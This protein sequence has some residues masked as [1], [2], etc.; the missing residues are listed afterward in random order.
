MNT[1]EFAAARKERFTSAD[2]EMK[3]F[4]QAA[5][6]SGMNWDDVV[7]AAAVLWLEIFSAEAPQAFPDKVL[8][9]F[10]RDLRASLA[11]T[12][13]PT[14]PPSEV[15]VER[16]TLWIGTYTVNSATFHGNRAVGAREMKWV[17]MHDA[18][19]RDTHVA[20]DGQ[21]VSVNGTFDVGGFALHFPGEPVGPP[22]IWINCRCVVAGGRIKTMAANGQT[23]VAAAPKEF[24]HEEEGDGIH[25]PE[26]EVEKTEAEPEIE[27]EMETPFHGVL[28][29]E[30]VESG[31]GRMF[32]VG[33][34]STR[35][36]PIPLLYQDATAEGHDGAVVIGRIDE[37]WMQDGL[38]KYRGAFRRTELAEEVIE[39]IAGGFLRGVSVDIDNAE[40]AT[41][42]S[43]TPNG[44][45]PKLV[46]KKARTAAATVVAIPAFEEAFIALGPDFEEDLTDEQVAALAAC[47]CGDA[48]A[49]TFEFDGGVVDLSALT[50][51]ELDAYDEMTPEEQEAF[52][53][54]RGLLTTTEAL[55][56]AGTFAPGTKD[57]PGWVTNPKATS[58]IRRYWTHGKCAAKIKWG[59]PGDFNRCRAQLAKY[60]KNPEYLAGTCANMHKEALGIWPR[61]HRGRAGVEGVAFSR[62]VSL[63]AAA[64]PSKLPPGE[65]FENP[66]LTG[67]TPLTVTP[68]GRVFG[69]IATWGVCH[70]GLSG[71]CTTAPHSATEYAHFRTGVVDTTTGEAF[72]GQL[73]IGT[74]HAAMSAKA[75]AAVEHYDNTGTAVADVSVGEDAFGIWTAGVTRPSAT[76]QQIRDL[77]ASAISGDWRDVRG[78]GQLE[79]VAALAVNVPGFG[80]PRVAL[81]ASGGVQTALVAADIVVP[82]ALTASAVTTVEDMAGIARAAARE[83][84][85]EQAREKRLAAMAPAQEALKRRRVT[86]AIKK[87]GDR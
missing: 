61:S 41:E 84:L 23:V 22:E 30:G 36:L 66:N 44:R 50:P 73:T 39:G 58:R 54:E 7:E 12:A 87:I 75:R 65:W 19:V 29:P 62:S 47:G 42:G 67:P 14:N 52:V 80:V 8:E 56:A 78:N 71:V 21:T 26:D 2:A 15:Q 24:P 70:I 51:E 60:V 82:G 17:T 20:A 45:A 72:V 38:L 10:Q 4:V 25:M 81:A 76:E 40:L 28:A 79:L 5:L 32:A 6:S 46:F 53:A 85:A 64:A 9:D 11:K 59:L 18:D 48:A 43:D 31:D 27:D 49:E 35:E 63:V 83:V 34:L 55:V 68:D 1:I 69:H 57:G 13:Q 86:A 3:P 33:A 74:G 16:V 77:K 37:V